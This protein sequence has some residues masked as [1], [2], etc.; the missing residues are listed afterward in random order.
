MPDVLEGFELT[1]AVADDVDVLPAADAAR[2]DLDAKA[3]RVRGTFD[4]VHDA[5]DVFVFAS[6]CDFVFVDELN[7]DCGYGGR[8]LKF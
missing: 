5:L 8:L 6:D 4:D 7:A 3:V 1:G 2:D